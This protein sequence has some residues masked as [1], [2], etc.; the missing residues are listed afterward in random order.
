MQKLW[1]SSALSFLSQSLEPVP[2]ELNEIDWKASLS[3]SKDRLTEHQNHAMRYW[4]AHSAATVFA[5]SVALGLKK[6]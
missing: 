1:V 5:R 3:T 2:H 4:L 6:W